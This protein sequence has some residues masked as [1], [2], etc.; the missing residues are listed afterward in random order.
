MG[1]RIAKG[2]MAI[3]HTSKSDPRVLI[4]LAHK[5]AAEALLSLLCVKSQASMPKPGM[6]TR[7]LARAKDARY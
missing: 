4:E 3:I 6:I 5:E 2:I 1:S 7:K